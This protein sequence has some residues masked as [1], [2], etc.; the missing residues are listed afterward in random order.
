MQSSWLA[1]PIM[2]VTDGYLLKLDAAIMTAAGAIAWQM[3]RETK[4]RLKGVGYRK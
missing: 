3:L 4:V 1:A 2:T